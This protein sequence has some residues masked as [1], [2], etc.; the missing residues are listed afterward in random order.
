M[1]TK[2]YQLQ[3]NLATNLECTIAIDTTIV[4]ENM[5]HEI[6]NFRIDAEGRLADND[7]NIY[8]VVAKMA[9][10][11]FM[12]LALEHCSSDVAYLGKKFL[13]L[14]GFPA[15]GITLVE[16]DGACFVDVDFMECE[17]IL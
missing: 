6:N 4:D 13:E 8:Q 10:A 9:G 17:E 16:L 7:D 2:K 12:N 5:A 14:E 1:S 3:D 11:A 15:T